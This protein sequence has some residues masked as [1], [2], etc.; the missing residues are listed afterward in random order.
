[1]A[2][3]DL[4]LTTLV[5][6]ELN[7]R[8]ETGHD[9]SGVAAKL[10]ALG[11]DVTDQALLG[12]LGEL[13]DL[14]P[15][16]AWHHDEPS[17]LSRIAGTFPEDEAP[18]RFG[19]VELADRVLGGWQGRIAGNMLGKPV[20]QG[21]VWTR[22]R[23]RSFLHLSAA[24]PIRD[25][26]PVPESFPDEYVL[27]DNWVQTTR[28]RINGSA[29]DDDIDYTI[30]GL[31]LLETHGPGL[32]PQHIAEGWLLRLPFHQVY[33][34]ERVA[35]RNL[36]NGLRPPATAE[37]HNPYR[38]W[39]GALIRADIFGYIHPGAPRRAAL[40]AYQDAVLSHRANGIYG[41]MW[42]AA[43]VAGA[44]TATSPRSLLADSIRY[45]PPRS[46]LAAALRQV[47]DLYDRSVGWEEAMT[48]LDRTTSHYHWVHTVNN[49]TVI[50]AGL[51]WGDGD[52]TRT[53]GLT[54]QGG[55]DTDSSGATAGSVAG[56]LTG[57]ASLPAHWIDPLEDRVRS[58]L[59][60]FDGV[61]I[62]ELATRTTRLAR[63]I[64]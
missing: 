22:D 43:L 14:T 36:V 4:D 35:Y 58:A 50:A 26:I 25:Y 1:M 5:D 24:Y 28:G 55:L 16:G 49:A 31:H 30:L 57:A 29:R 45:V 27:R 21:E 15:S 51:L 59:F 41:E 23:I 42:A 38:E 34:A 3:D 10:A 52:F 46:R 60:G 61:S 8:L 40:A 7:Q 6:A 64:S 19:E 18:V 33:T 37:H 9:V 47:L 62:S 44:F 12:L 53:I 2:H 20:E 32:R 13:E 54:V 63:K 17:E 11:T 48:E 39:I 56:I